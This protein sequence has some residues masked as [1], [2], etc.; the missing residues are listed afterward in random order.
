MKR[1][2]VVVEADECAAELCNDVS[3]C[4]Y[5]TKYQRRTLVALHDNPDF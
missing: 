3:I 1:T 4:M 2:D 5:P